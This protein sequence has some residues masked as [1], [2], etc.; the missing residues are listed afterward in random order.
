MGSHDG[1]RTRTA[2]P[3]AV[4]VG[5]GEED[6]FGRK[7]DATAVQEWMA[8]L[9]P[10]IAIVGPKG[11]GKTIYRLF[12]RSEPQ[13]VPPFVSSAMR[14][15]QIGWGEELGEALIRKTMDSPWSLGPE[16][17]M[18]GLSPDGNRDYLPRVDPTGGF[19]VHRLP[20]PDEERS[21][22]TSKQAS[23]RS[24][25]GHLLDF[26]GEFF[27]EQYAPL[28]GKRDDPFLDRPFLKLLGRCDSIVL[29]IPF[30]LLLPDHLRADPPAHLEALGQ[31]LHKSPDRVREDRESHRHGLQLTLGQW[32]AKL[33]PLF[34]KGTGPQ[35]LVVFTMLGKDWHR[36]FADRVCTGDA[37]DR[38][39]RKEGL[40]NL[41]NEDERSLAKSLARA[42]GRLETPLARRKVSSKYTGWVG[43]LVSSVE[44][45]WQTATLRSLLDSLHQ[46]LMEYVEAVGACSED[47]EPGERIARFLEEL[48][49]RIGDQRMRYTAMNV[50][51]ESH[52]KTARG[53][54][55][56]KWGVEDTG[57]YFPSVYFCGWLAERR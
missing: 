57:V 7:M 35:L 45:Q 36:E 37:W 33:D 40:A 32:L 34:V 26:P 18:K 1:V 54:D 12:L 55:R 38:K 10:R 47:N 52:A 44:E 5:K 53:I 29:M 28:R 56:L 49:K 24:K 42:R 25:G 46:D 2:A 13:A 21:A 6:V 41:L 17:I 8:T 51:A 11:S 23:D 3:P 22:T 27:G 43:A 30:W 39:R 15:R 14:V 48:R 9:D 19:T 4:E 31:H 16:P 50:I 20:V